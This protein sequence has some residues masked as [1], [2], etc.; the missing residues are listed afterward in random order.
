M[1]KVIVIASGKGGT[2]KTTLTANLGAALAKRDKSVV[3]V[4][5]DMGLR[6]LDVALGL[7]S[8][9]VYDVAD[10]I[11]ETC[12]LD[13]ALIKHSA[14]DSLFFIPAP[15]TRDASS[16]AASVIALNNQPKPEVMQEISDDPGKTLT[17]ENDEIS[18][19]SENSIEEKE[20]D[21]EENDVQDNTE[22]DELDEAETEEEKEPVTLE[23][24]WRDFWTR[25]SERFDYCIIDSPAGIEG[26]FKYAVYGADE[27]VIVTLAETAAL[28]DADRVVD[29]FEDAGIENVRLVINRIRPD[30]ITKGIMMDIDTC[31]EMLEIP[32]LG[33]IGDDEE[34]ISSSLK[35]ELAVNNELSHAGTAIR[36]IAARIIGENVP[37]MEFKD[38]SRKSIWDRIKSI[39][40]KRKG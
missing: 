38:D 25:L 17:I 18:E 32:I 16:I 20:S 19:D 5:M 9:I 12:T 29:V 23:Q 37:I 34:L 14:F 26:G 31:I 24:I 11:E 39:F 8:S 2:G 3:V 22:E 33:I 10:V 13:D 36:N 7:E 6:N 1:G 21:S 28:R 30:M 35:G 4:D 40:F 27:A 15:Q